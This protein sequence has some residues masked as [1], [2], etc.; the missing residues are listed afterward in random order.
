MEVMEI[1]RELV[2]L[3]FLLD[4]QPGNRIFILQRAAE[5]ERELD[6]K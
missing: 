6:N 5:L 1:A 4:R 2:N 3:V